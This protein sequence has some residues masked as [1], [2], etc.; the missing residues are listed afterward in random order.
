MGYWASKCSL[1]VICRWEHHTCGRADGGHAI[2]A[3]AWP[4]P[5]GLPG[6]TLRTLHADSSGYAICR[7]ILSRRA[8]YTKL[9]AK[10]HAHQ[11]EA[12]CLGVCLPPIHD[13]NLA[14]ALHVSR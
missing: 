2:G 7:N 9:Y 6:P 4:R 13:L 12:S 3:H 1:A 8:F 5:F 11:A 14:I 10:Q